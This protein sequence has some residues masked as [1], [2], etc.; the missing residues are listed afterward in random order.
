M[1]KHWIYLLK[2][3]IIPLNWP[4]NVVGN[5]LTILGLQFKVIIELT[6]S[7]ED[8]SSLHRNVFHRGLS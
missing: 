1:L 5:Y 3:K 6:I 2:K 8:D 7:P 4:G